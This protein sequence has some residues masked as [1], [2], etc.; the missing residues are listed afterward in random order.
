MSS[1]IFKYSSNTKYLNKD[2]RGR[3]N[4]NNFSLLGVYLN[5]KR[6]SIKIKLLNIL[7][8]HHIAVKLGATA[9]GFDKWALSNVLWIKF[10][11]NHGK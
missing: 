1:P 11:S 10:Y 6:S 8:D 5:D 3:Y 4:D 9:V 7:K 2:L